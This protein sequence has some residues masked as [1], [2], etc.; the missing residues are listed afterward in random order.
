MRYSFKTKPWPH[1]VTGFRFVMKEL[2]ST[3]SAGLQVPMRWGKS[4]LAIDCASALHLKYGT[5]RVLVVTTTSGLGVWEREIPKHCPYPVDVYN[6]LSKM[7]YQSRNAALEP[8]VGA[9]TFYVVHHA[10]LYGRDHGWGEDPREWTPGPNA[11]IEAFDPEMIVMDESHRIGDPSSMQ[12]KMAYRYGRRARFRLTLTGTMFHRAP[13]MVFGQCKFLDDSM[14]GTAI[15][16]FKRLHVQY[17]GYGNYEIVGYKNLGLMAEK[18]KAKVFIEEYVAHTKPNVTTTPVEMEECTEVYSTMEREA[19]VTVGKDVILAPIIL[20]KHLRC[21]QIAGGW[22]K[23]EQGQYVQVGQEKARCITDKFTLMAEEGIDKIVV[24]CMFIPE[25]RDIARA[26]KAAGYAFVTL[27]GGVPR[28]VTRD[29]R[30][31]AF[32][33]DERPTVFV[34][35]MQAAAEAIDLSAA[36]DLI[37][38][39]LPQS[40]LLY[41]QFGSRIERYKETRV[42]RYDHILMKGTRDVVTWLAMNLK[43]DVAK[44]LVTHPEIVERITRR[45]DL[46]TKKPTYAGG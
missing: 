40:Y 25:I 17:G 16:P 37:Y 21:S 24:G 34:A 14:F 3:G 19:V 4:K 36:Q 38:Y 41:D 13:L 12:C 44:F 27:H 23:T 7:V 30:I 45:D 5:Q 8:V 20:T 15:T 18:L 26:A 11:A 39:S 35:Q 31:A 29:R 28:G 22:L 2:M 9:L 43:I 1:Q 33:E 10:V 6:Y 46:Y 32:Q 42:L